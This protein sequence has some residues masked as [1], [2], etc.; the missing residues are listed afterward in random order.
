MSRHPRKNLEVFVGRNRKKTG[1]NPVVVVAAVDRRELAVVDRKEL[2]V[3]D[4]TKLVVVDHTKLV[5][6]DHMKSA[7]LHRAAVGR[8]VWDSR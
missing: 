7:V 8:A 5:V 3:V 2:A 6:V 1:H 4:H